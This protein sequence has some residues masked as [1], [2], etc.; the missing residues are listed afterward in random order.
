MHW[1]F[2]FQ[3]F[4]VRQK[5]YLVRGDVRVFNVVEH[6]KGKPTIGAIELVSLCPSVVKVAHGL[7]Y[8]SVRPAN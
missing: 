7:K 2:V 1:I 8:V 4:R 3:R 5:N 6:R